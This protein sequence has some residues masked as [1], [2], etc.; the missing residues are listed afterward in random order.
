MIRKIFCQMGIAVRSLVRTACAHKTD[1]RM[2]FVLSL[3]YFLLFSMIFAFNVDVS[4]QPQ[5]M[6]YDTYANI[7]GENPK[8]VL[9]KVLA[10]NIRHPLYVLYNIPALLV[11][12]M[13]V[14][15]TTKWCVFAFFSSLVM[16]ESNLLIYK[17][18]RFYDVPKSVGYCSV[19]L[20]SSFAHVILLAGQAETFVYTMCFSLL[21]ILVVLRNEDNKWKDNILFMLLTGTTVTNVAKFFMLRLCRSG[22]SFKRAFVETWR[23]SYLFLSF[24]AFTVLGLLYRIFIK[25]LPWRE[26][27]MGDTINYIRDVP[28][29]LLL[30]W[31]NFF[32]EPLL[33]HSQQDVVY[34]LD[35]TMLGDY[36]EPLFEL[37]ML[38]LYVLC[39]LSLFFH[40][41]SY[42]GKV[43]LAFL[44][45]DFLIHFVIGYGKNE[46]QLFCLHWLF[47]LPVLLALLVKDFSRTIRRISCG[48]LLVLTFCFMSYNVFC[49]INSIFGG[50]L[51]R[52]AISMQTYDKQLN[53]L[54]E[55][56]TVVNVTNDTLFFFGMG[57]RT[58]LVFKVKGNDGALVDLTHDRE[59]FHSQS[60][61][62]VRIEPS[63]YRVCM[64]LS[65]GQK[66]NIFENEN[67]VFCGKGDE[68]SLVGGTGTKVCLPTFGDKSF[69]KVLRVL[70][71]EVLFNVKDG[72]VYPNIFVYDKP[73]LRDAAMAGMVFEKT[74]NTHLI[75]DWVSQMDVFYDCQNGGARELDNLGE[76]LYLKGLF[77]ET[78]T[79]ESVD[80]ACAEIR[81]HVVCKG[82]GAYIVGQT[83]FLPNNQYITKFARVGLA[84]VGGK[85]VLT[86][87]P[88]KGVYYDLLWFADSSR[89]NRRVF[90]IVKDGI[91][92][93]RGHYDFPYIEWAR[94]HYYGTWNMPFSNSR[95]VLSW[96]ADASSANYEGMRRISSA[97]ANRGMAFPH[98]WTAAEMFLRLYDVR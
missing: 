63:D 1:E 57:N 39:G 88:N 44:S 49:Y 20:F 4:L 72:K 40:R 80:K 31:E 9:R 83:D 42:I 48:V 62:N 92:S 13:L 73:W 77:S 50:Q 25:H 27:V 90:R 28:D 30:V 33:F 19:L 93:W 78:R 10:W 53:A 3:A 38:C 94:G 56:G 43:C 5:I 85:L 36:P 79:D 59:L 68:V 97:A 24:W 26:A 82:D 66:Y 52:H 81:R 18:C 47:F 98:T 34:T 35:T 86:N 65:D 64:E 29:R 55:S 89:H 32:C 84:K 17:I 58:K 37:L 71:H 60:I 14:G 22:V 96:E 2:V 69:G 76:F 54:R 8:I 21:A 74:G 16:A 91:A 15:G 75:K 12:L 95:L 11:S 23:S 7:D 45:V 46:L 61:R 6:G 67:G 87:A 41:K 70:L 51:P